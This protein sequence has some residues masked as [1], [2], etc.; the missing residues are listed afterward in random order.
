[1]KLQ[2]PSVRPPAFLEGSTAAIFSPSSNTA[3]KF[4]VRTLAGARR[5]QEHLGSAV[6][7]E[8]QSVSF[9]YRAGT[10]MALCRQLESLFRDP[11]VALIVCAIGGYNSNSLLSHLDWEVLRG[12][13]TQICGYSDATALLVAIHAMTRQ[14]VLHGPALLPQWGDPNGPLP[15]TVQSFSAA[16]NGTLDRWEPVT[17]AY[18]VSPKTRW[19]DPISSFHDNPATRAIPRVLRA[20]VGQGRLLGGNIE[21]LN[22]LLGT[23]FEPSFEGR[24]LFIEATG[25][26]AFLPRFHRAL[27]HLRHAG[28]FERI[29]GLVVGRCPDALEV[30]SATLDKVIIEVIEGSDFP[31]VID[32]EVGHTEPIPTLPIGCEARLAAL[33][34]SCTWEVL[35]RAAA[36]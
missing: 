19:E 35:E 11:E 36:R 4:P 24:L 31:V 20:G 22:M 27:V 14:V 34:G 21:T 13:P 26:E 9:G 25:A 32:F 15:E 33:G 28:V 8:M 1:M 2:V 30:D 10:A 29:Q 16:I 7:C 17:N 6:R 3:A 12:H 18:W 5:L 23:P